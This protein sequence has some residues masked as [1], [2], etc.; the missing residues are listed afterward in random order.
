[1][2]SLGNWKLKYLRHSEMMPLSYVLKIFIRNRV[3]VKSRDCRSEAY[4][5]EGRHLELDFI[6][7]NMTSS[8]AD[9]PILQKTALTERQNG[10]LA[11]EY[12]HLKF[13]DT[14]IK[15]PADI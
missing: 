3:T 13:A 2:I 12:K 4:N 10:F 14:A 6:K 7:C 9:K 8:L 15:M 5:N 11:T 1:M